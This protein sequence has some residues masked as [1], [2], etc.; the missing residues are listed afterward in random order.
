MAQPQQ[1]CIVKQPTLKT[2]TCACLGPHVFS[3]HCCLPPKFC[4]CCYTHTHTCTV[5]LQASKCAPNRT[6]GSATPSHQPQRSHLTTAAAPTRVRV[7]HS[8]SVP[9]AMPHLA[10]PQV[11]PRR[12]APA[13]ATA[14]AARAGSPAGLC[15]RCLLLPCW[16][17][18]LLHVLLSQHHQSQRHTPQAPV[19][20]QRPT[21][22][23]GSMFQCAC[24][25]G[26]HGGLAQHT[27]C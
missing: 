4:P 17:W 22:G 1:L 15:L 16:C 25:H 11:H 2:H 27:A 6:R 21:S 19:Q 13:A 12:A 24:S 14:L 10:A 8:R 26:A 18:L 20:Q 23:L 5:L 7:H 3:L 9:A